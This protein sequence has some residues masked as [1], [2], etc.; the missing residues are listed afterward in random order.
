MIAL[1]IYLSG[2]LLVWSVFAYFVF[3][4][5]YEV[6]KK[7]IASFIGFSFLSYLSILIFIG[8]LIDDYMEKHGD[9]VVFNH[10]NEDD[11]TEIL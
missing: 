1:Y 2:V 8:I 5:K 10:K 3:V 7:D 9:E 11:D 4:K 6:R